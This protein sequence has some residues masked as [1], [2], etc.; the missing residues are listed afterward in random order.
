MFGVFLFPTIRII[1]FRRS[2]FFGADSITPAPKISPD[3][4]G[5]NQLKSFNK[6]F[7]KKVKINLESLGISCIFDYR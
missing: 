4:P 1:T 3:R 5:E 7:R 2:T 6:I